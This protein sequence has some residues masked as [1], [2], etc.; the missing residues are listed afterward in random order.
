ML[1][2]LDHNTSVEH[3]SQ[4]NLRQKH[5]MDGWDGVIAT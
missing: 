3:F 4:T 1:Y 2:I 5:I